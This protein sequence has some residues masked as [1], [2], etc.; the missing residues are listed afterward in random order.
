M[1]AARPSKSAVANVIAAMR[2]AGLVPGIVR[3]LPD[4]GFEVAEQNQVDEFRIDLCPASYAFLAGHSIRVHV[5]SSNFPRF[6]RNLNT[7]EDV[8]TGTRILTA[9]NTVLHTMEYPSH[10]LL[11]ISKR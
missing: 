4:G 5:T 11:P 3:V 10:I 8:A 9:R 1:P 6:S 2:E 7:G